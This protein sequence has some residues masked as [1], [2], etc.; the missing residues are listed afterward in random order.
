VDG[1]VGTATISITA[2]PVLAITVDPPAL[3]L[4][5]GATATLVATARGRNGAAL[6]GRGFSFASADPSIATVTSAG[7][8]TAVKTGATTITVTSEGQFVTVAVDVS[9]A[10]V[11]AV[12]VTLAE[13]ARFVGQ[14][15]QAT[16][17]LHDAQDNVLTGRDIVWS[18]SNARVAS[19]SPAGLV[20][21]LAVGTANIVATSEGKSGLAAVTIT[22]APVATVNVTLAKSKF[23]LAQS[24]QA[25]AVTLDPNG[26]ILTGRTVTWSSSNPTVAFVTA[27]GVVT[28][29]LP[30]TANIIAT[31][32]GKTGFAV[33]TVV[34]FPVANVTVAVSPAA[35]NIGQSSQAIATTIDTAGRTV[36]DR[37]IVWAS[38]A[39]VV[40]SVNGDGTITALAPGTANIIATSEGVSGSSP[41]TVV[42]APV[43][44]LSIELQSS[45]LIAGKTTTSIVTLR[46]ANGHILT[47]RAIQ[48]ASSNSAVATVSATGVV[49]A[50]SPGTANITAAAE[51]KSS[52]AGLTVTAVPV[53]TVTVTMADSSLAPGATTQAV[54]VTLDASS[55]VLS[56]RVVVWTSSNTSVATV[57]AVTGLV[58]AIAAGSAS[59][60]ATRETKVGSAPLTVVVT[61]APVNGVQVT[62][63]DSSDVDTGRATFSKEGSC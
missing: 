7:L 63:A 25:T 4:L 1:I 43:A 8:V 52:S 24:T 19:V 5:P 46:D 14:T 36:S 28:G 38:S 23:G 15:T 18:S 9:P 13:P 29:L 41:V 30:G 40:A 31:S 22:P 27:A 26:R 48:Y 49:T 51:G 53:S 61:I 3:G 11:A 59:I 58:K 57:D 33:A 34:L 32:E 17:V 54:A 10:P 6:S 60:R 50:V 35:L 2:E 39:P 20:T 56:G 16:A 21:A 62:L 42:L 37:E 12:T 55:N 44:A 45:A 47:E